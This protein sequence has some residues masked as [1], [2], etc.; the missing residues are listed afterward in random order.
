MRGMGGRPLDKDYA[1]DLLL[2]AYGFQRFIPV[3]VDTAKGENG[4]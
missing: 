4:F 3:K 1:N 2:G